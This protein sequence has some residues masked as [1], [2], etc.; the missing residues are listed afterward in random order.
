M[1][2]RATWKGHLKL[3]LVSFPVRVYN[4]TTTTTRVA[5][6][7]LHKD[8]NQRLK[9]KMVCPEHGDVERAD[10]IKGYEFEKGRYVPVDAED[11]EHIQLETTK[12][13][14][15]VQ[16]V[17]PEELSPVYLNAPYYLA[18]EGPVAEE[19]YRVVREALSRSGKVGIGRFVVGG[20]ENLIALE[21]DGRGFRMTTL[22]SH[23]EVR[24]SDAYFEDITDGD[25]DASQL[26]LAE[27]LV[28]EKTAP[29]DPEEFKD[30]YQEALLDVIKAKVEGKEPAILEEAAAPPTLSFMDALQASLEQAGATKKPTRKKPPAKSVKKTKRKKA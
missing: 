21:V 16:F 13:I 1:P 23:R 30:R 20:R 29:L 11:I 26:K 6:N 28:R 24:S 12:T 9:Q 4:A 2:P 10:I 5:L 14:E 22:R 17:E 7:Q 15:I 19:A 3:S 27:D 18:P 8:C 25:V